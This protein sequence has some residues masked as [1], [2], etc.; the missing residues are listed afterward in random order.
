MGE[1][2]ELEYADAVAMRMILP[3]TF[4]NDPPNIRSHKAIFH[5][6]LSLE[7]VHLSASW[8]PDHT[9]LDS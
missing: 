9:L 4:P 3:P 6:N 5:P 8:Q 7:G 2:G 1:S